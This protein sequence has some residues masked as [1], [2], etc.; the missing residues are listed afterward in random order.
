MDDTASA[1][2]PT[3]ERKKDE[4]RGRIAEAVMALI[5]EG[6]ELNHDRVAERTGVARR[7]VYR[8]FPDREALLQTAWLK[9][10]EL[11]R[12]DTSFPV[13]VDELLASL[14][15]THTGFDRIAPLATLVRATP[16]GRAIRRSQN[17]RR[18]AAYAA[19]AK[20]LVA[21]LPKRDRLLA[22]AML[23]VLHTTPWLE[24]RDNWG[25]GG[26][27]TARACGWAIRT[28]VADLK[29]RRG[30]PLDEDLPAPTP[31]RS[32]QR[33]LGSSS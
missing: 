30:L 12:Q 25:L 31:T 16:Q 33:K 10:N 5:A 3:R 32:S 15:P 4:V 13:T 23:Q 9:L 11:L 8:Y 19:I 20:E 24:M 14:V 28:L 17:K 27:E 29:A 6:V 26:E 22:T 7:T 18:T 2:P 1:S 21:D